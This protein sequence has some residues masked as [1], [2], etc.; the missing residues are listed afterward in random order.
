MSRW[1]IVESLA[2]D[3]PY[4][5]VQVTAGGFGKVQFAAVDQAAAL[6]FLDMAET[7]HLVSGGVF[8]V[9]EPAPKKKTRSRSVN[10]RK[11]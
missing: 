9:P 3:Y 1:I 7:F 8:V 11:K 6:A 10:S 4:R 5:L 2:E